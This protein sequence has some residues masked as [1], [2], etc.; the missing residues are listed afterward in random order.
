MYSCFNQLI[1]AMVL[2]LPCSQWSE[3]KPWGQTQWYP[4]SVKPLWHVPPFSQTALSQP[5]LKGINDNGINHDLVVHKIYFYHLPDWKSWWQRGLQIRS[6]IKTTLKARGEK[7]ERNSIKK[8]KAFHKEMNVQIKHESDT[9]MG[10]ILGENPTEVQNPS[11]STNLNL[12][13]RLSTRTRIRT[14]S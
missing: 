2:F 1:V 9:T 7:Y 8:R 13:T 10:P 12:T 4:L 14:R 11:L 5:L 6:V 3:V